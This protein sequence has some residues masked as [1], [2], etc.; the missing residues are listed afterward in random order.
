[1]RWADIC[2][3]ADK[4]PSLES[5]GQEDV[6]AGNFTAKRVSRV[7]DCGLSVSRDI[8]GSIGA[9]TEVSGYE[10]ALSQVF[11]ACPCAAFVTGTP[12]CPSLLL[13]HTPPSSNHSSFQISTLS[14]TRSRHS[15]PASHAAFLCGAETAIKIL[16]SP[17]STRPRRC[18]ILT[19]TKSYFSRTDVAMFCSDL[20]ARGA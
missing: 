14:F 2:M 6:V 15:S 9:Q 5:R 13:L 11:G 19:P 1:M 4:F 16:S 7:G 3:Y 18:V 8:I 12:A 10:D 20:R 17:M